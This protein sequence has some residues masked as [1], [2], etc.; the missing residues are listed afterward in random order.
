MANSFVQLPGDTARHLARYLSIA[1][2]IAL[3]TTSH[4]LRSALWTDQ[5]ATSLWEALI[6]GL[7][8]VASQIAARYADSTDSI[9]AGPT[10]YRLLIAMPGQFSSTILIGSAASTMSDSVVICPCQCRHEHEDGFPA[11][12][13]CARLLRPALAS[14]AP[15]G[16]PARFEFP[17]SPHVNGSVGEIDVRLVASEWQGQSVNMVVDQ[18]DPDACLSFMLF[19][20]TARVGF[21]SEVAIAHAADRALQ[22][23]DMAGRLVFFSAC[24]N[25]R[26]FDAVVRVVRRSGHRSLIL[27]SG[28]C[29]DGDVSE[30]PRMVCASFI[31]ALL[32]DYIEHP[33]DPIRAVVIPPPGLSEWIHLFVKSC[34]A[35]LPRGPYPLPTRIPTET[36]VHAF[37][38]VGQ[39]AR[40]DNYSAGFGTGLRAWAYFYDCNFLVRDGAVAG[41]SSRP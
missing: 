23:D 28:L 10:L 41:E 6:A 8:D 37:R 39:L 30:C 32:R 26:F 17:P 18:L 38:E 24:F 14:Q 22:E 7:G 20:H 40:S 2:V 36:D 13:P 19:L 35:R 34:A 33:T 11:K 12:S 15:P 3:A 5:E 27:P 1:E 31:T 16:P 25:D 21:T 29:R 9:G 4:A